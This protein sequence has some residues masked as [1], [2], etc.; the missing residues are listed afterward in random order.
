MLIDIG[1]IKQDFPILKR[2]VNGHPLT[3]LDNAATTQKPTVLIEALKNYY[4]NINANI[5]RGIHK[6]SEEASDAYEKTR[7]LV[8]VFIGANEASEII[9][10]SGTT[11][12][13]NLVARTYGEENIKPSDHILVTGLEHH[14]NFIPWQ[15]LAKRKNAVLDI[16]PITKD[17]D[18]DYG[19]YLELL[20]NKPKIVAVAHVSNAL[21]TILD[22]KKIISDAHKVGAKVLIDAAQSVPHMMVNV[23]DLDCD[24]LA[25][26]AH[27][28][29][30]PFAVGVLYGKKELLRN[31]PPYNYGGGMVIDVNDERSIWN[32]LP[33]KFE[34][35]TAN[36]ADVIS[37][38][39]ALE[40]LEKLKMENIFEHGIKL[41][42]Y[43]RMSLSKMKEVELY[44]PSESGK[45]IACLSFNIKN[46]HPHDTA[47]ILNEHG[48]AIRSGHLCAKPLMD[49]LGIQAI[50]RASFYI[51]NDEKDVDQLVKGI[52][53]V[54]KV[55]N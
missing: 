48:I 33:Y 6:L 27:K 32:A 38:V 15:E 18:L 55:F 44:G 7:A 41:I 21:G 36:I 8:S 46:I 50:N 22:I 35:G 54:I 45:S 19:A 47:T 4:E 26:S 31:M 11:E 43:A 39:S 52:E 24:F 40:Y 16:V 51:Y 37:F 23:S 3:Y 28:M 10:T 25:F 42:D 20:K 34:A 9:F 5:H 30:G 12:S 1:K 13:I 29:L 53:A 2:E 49:R 17:G 14:S